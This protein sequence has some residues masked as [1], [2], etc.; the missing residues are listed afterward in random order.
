MIAREAQDRI[1]AV[2]FS[3]HLELERVPDM[4]RRF[5]VTTS[6]LVSIGP[7]PS[8]KVVAALAHHGARWPSGTHRPTNRFASFSPMFSSNN[9]IAKA[10]CIGAFPFT[11]RPSWKSMVPKAI[12]RF[13]ISAWAVPACS[14]A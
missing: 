1:Y 2:L 3:A 6:A 13:E 9:A 8:Q 5:A 14:A 4:A 11:T 7:R 12:S 10:E